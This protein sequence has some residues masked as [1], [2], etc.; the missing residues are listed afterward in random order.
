MENS[1][2]AKPEDKRLR[3]VAIAYYAVMLVAF[4]IG[5]YGCFS[6]FW[7]ARSEVE[8]SVQLIGSLPL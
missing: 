5:L 7:L 8:H 3:F 1:E 6:L 2:R 4:A